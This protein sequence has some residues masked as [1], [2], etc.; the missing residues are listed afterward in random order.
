MAGQNRVVGT[1]AA[2]TAQ[3]VSSAPGTERTRVSLITVAY[4]AAPTQAGV[5]V[6]VNSGAGA[7]YDCPI[8]TGAANARYYKFLPSADLFI[9][10]DDVLDVTAPAGGAGITSSIAIYTGEY[11]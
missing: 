2:N 4:S 8:D 11:N 7:E 5:T 9:N 10:A 1:S 6:T 3:T